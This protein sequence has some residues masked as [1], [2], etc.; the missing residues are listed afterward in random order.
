VKVAFDTSVLVA[1]SVAGHVHE[2]RAR[3]WFRAA[4]EKR[5]EA[6]ATTHAFAETWA[7][8]TA[9]PVAPRIAPDAA[10]RV[11][12]RL[13]RYVR[14]AVLRWEDY[15]SA[16]ARCTERGLRS[17]SAYDAL[18]FVGAARE[19]A[20]VFL[21]FNTRHFEALAAAG[22]PRIVAPPDPPRLLGR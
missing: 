14:P 15:R 17:G 10:E 8:L 5:I 13:A 2:Q 9:L 20:D 3:V 11:I 22:D 19:G 12:R 21:T 1:G 7:A 16:L 6:V 4:R 18:H